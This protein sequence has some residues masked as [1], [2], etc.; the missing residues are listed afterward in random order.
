M[1]FSRFYAFDS[2]LLEGWFVSEIVQP[3]CVLV[4]S[5]QQIVRKK[6]KRYQTFFNQNM[7]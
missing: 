6:E 1:C 5:K 2:Y 7:F 4:D 3:E